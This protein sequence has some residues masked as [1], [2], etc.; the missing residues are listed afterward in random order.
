MKIQLQARERQFIINA[1]EE[2][3]RQTGEK[4]SIRFVMLLLSERYED[5]FESTITK[6]FDEK[7]RTHEEEKARKELT[8]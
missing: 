1:A 8:K 7:I 4:Y 5:E 2:F 3:E 6:I